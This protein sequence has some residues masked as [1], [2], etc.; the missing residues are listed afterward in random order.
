MR[1]ERDVRPLGQTLGSAALG[2]GL[3]LGILG[4]GFLVS[5][6]ALP[7]GSIVAASTGAPSP[8]P[9]A[10]T[11]PAPMRVTPAPTTAPPATPTPT[12]APTADP[13]V[14]TAYSGQGIQLA[15]LTIPAGYTVTSPIDGSVRIEVYQFIGGEIRT[16][17]EAAG[18]PSFPYIFIRS[19]SREIKIRPGAIDRDI[20]LLV[21][22]GD[23]VPAG[24]PLF[25]TLTT[26][27]SSWKTFYDSAV[28]AQVLVS[29]TEQPSG[30][31]VDPVPVFKK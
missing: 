9:V 26:G 6:M 13:M 8:T 24:T 11:P 2:L 30:A 3:G 31:E 25:K 10:T 7:D 23:N 5:R 22:D 4:I 14:V 12:P 19:A 1:D 16:G 18:E 17:A 15:A 21:K 27:A 20:Q 29:V 28:T